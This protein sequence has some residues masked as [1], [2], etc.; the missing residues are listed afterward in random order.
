MQHFYQLNKY[1]QTHKL[2]VCM[3]SNSVLLAKGSAAAFH[4]DR[5]EKERTSLR[6][7][8]KGKDC[9]VVFDKLE[10]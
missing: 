9:S 2:F 10:I 4:R 7:G 5:E 1:Q 8:C 6:D 3:L